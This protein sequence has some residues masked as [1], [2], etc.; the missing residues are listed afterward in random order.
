MKT[1]PS[2]GPGG[3]DLVK[4]WGLDGRLD[5]DYRGIAW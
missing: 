1:T 2:G 3:R 5:L 4:T